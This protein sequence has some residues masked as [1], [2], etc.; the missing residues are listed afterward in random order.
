[1]RDPGRARTIA[2]DNVNPKRQ[3]MSMTT[4]QR[5]QHVLQYAASIFGRYAA[6]SWLS[7]EVPALGR[8]TPDSLLGSDAG[9]CAVMS[10][11]DKLDFSFSAAP[12]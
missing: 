2:A 10:M 5:R 11:L 9:Y 8:A 4:A 12:A 6:L 7:A 3:S 1:L